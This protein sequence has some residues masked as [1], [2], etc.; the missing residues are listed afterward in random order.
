MKITRITTEVLRIPIRHPGSLGVGKLDEIENVLVRVETSDGLVGIGESSPWPVFAESCWSVKAALD[1]YLGP[2]L[3]GAN[4]FDIE[5]L[6][7]KMD[8]T[9]AD[10]P[11][12]KAAV[13]IA[14]HDLVGKAL[15]QPVYNLLGGLVRDRITMSYSIANQDVERD[16]REVAWLRERGVRVFKIKTGVVPPAVDR[17]RV[18]AIRD[19]VGPDADI[20][21]DYNQSIEVDQAIR[22]LRDLEAFRPTFIE[23]PTRRWDID[24]LARIAAAIDTPIMADEAVFSPA[25]AMRVVRQGAADLISIKLMKPGGIARSR[26]VAAIAEAAGVPCYAGAMWESGVGIAAS[27]H[28]MAAN[29]NV[30]YGSDFY[31]PYFLMERDIV[32]QPPRFE[33]GFVYVPHGPG[34]GVELDEDAVRRFRIA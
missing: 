30:K 34:L 15:G 5:R 20:R 22:I 13:D 28:F 16:V 27:L 11:F 6:L 29:P 33:D 14:L 1:H 12:A 24:N 26:R 25:D 3:V 17:E 7:I 9:L 32:K 23:Q 10:A 21:L 19:L 18:R 31:I 4:P 2:C 8:Q